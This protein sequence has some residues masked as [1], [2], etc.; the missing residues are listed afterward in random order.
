MTA[1]FENLL[2][3]YYLQHIPI[4][5]IKNDKGYYNYTDL[6]I[7]AGKLLRMGST[8]KFVINHAKYVHGITIPD[9][10]FIFD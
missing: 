1:Y 3:P 7:I 5:I 10:F 9:E 8:V 2:S 6:Q 4:V